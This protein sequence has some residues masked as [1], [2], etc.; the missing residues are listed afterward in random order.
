MKYPSNAKPRPRPGSPRPTHKPFRPAPRGWPARPI[1]KLPKLPA[2][3]LIVKGVGKVAARLIPFAGTALTVY[4]V[5]RWYSKGQAQPAYINPQKWELRQTCPGGSNTGR[6]IHRTSSSQFV[7]GMSSASAGIIG[8]IDSGTSNMQAVLSQPALNG[9]AN[10]PRGNGYTRVSTDP[11]VNSFLPAVV[12][13]IFSPARPKPAKNPTELPIHKPY[14]LP[15]RLPASYPRPQPGEQPGKQPKSSP[16]PR[17]R[18]RQRPH[19]NGLPF[20]NLPFMPF[21]IVKAPEGI[22]PVVPDIVITVKPGS[23]GNGPNRPPRTDERSTAGRDKP[24]AKREV[25]RKPNVRTVAGKAWGI[26]NIST[27]TM[28]FVDSVFDA[29]PDDSPCKKAAKKSSK[30]GVATPYAKAKA[31]Y[32]C[33]DQIDIGNALE[34]YVNNQVE[35][36][37]FGTMGRALGKATG[38]FGITTGLNRAIKSQQ[39]Q[40]TGDGLGIGDLIPQ[41]D[42]D[43][44]TGEMTI[45]VPAYGSVSFGK[46]GDGNV[47]I[48]RPKK[49]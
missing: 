12:P 45:T 36:Y 33:F 27:E 11:A 48:K 43:D 6:W 42:I 23:P 29:L 18:P 39:K 22:N 28:D 37:V 3:S 26:I 17:G 20:V 21:P 4:E 44:E 5:A 2:S 8:T 9:A 35:D 19:P 30:I 24:P 49:E 38:N 14:P 13:E 16:R 10:S 41:I 1:P 46:F 32:D 7:C 40:A 31:I 34:N 25:E 15:S 47:S